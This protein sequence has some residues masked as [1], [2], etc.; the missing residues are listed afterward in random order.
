MCRPSVTAARRGDAQPDGVGAGGGDVDGVPEPLPGPGPAQVVAAAGVGGGLQVDPVGAV[1]VGGAVD[2]GDVVGGALP[3]GVV[4][5]RLHGAGHRRRGPAV[6]GLGRGAAAGGFVYGYVAHAHPGAGAGRAGGRGAVADS[7]GVD[8]AHGDVEDHEEP[9][10]DGGLPGGDGDLVFADGPFQVAVDVPAQLL[11][12]GV[13]PVHDDRVGVV[14]GLAAAAG[15]QVAADA[16]GLVAR[17]AGVHSAVE[18][19]RDLAEGV[20]VLH[21]VEFADAGPVGGAHAAGGGAH[22]P[23]R[24]P[25][26]EAVTRGWAARWRRSSPSRRRAAPRRTC[27]ASRSAR[28]SRFRWSRSA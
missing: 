26:A 13:G 24:G 16:V 17:A 12:A 1:A 6:G 15:Q 14:S 2:G 27:S 18:G 4:V 25:V 19:V 9:V 8:A 21:D 3:A 10:I 20:D 5:L 28:R 23:E 11:G 7:V 22:R